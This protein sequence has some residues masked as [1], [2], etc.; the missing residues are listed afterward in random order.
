MY[1]EMAIAALPEALDA[2][3]TSIWLLPT[4]TSQF[5]V[6]SASFSQGASL[7]WVVPET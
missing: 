7:R 6:D 4:P 3:R 5:V 1:D 2:A